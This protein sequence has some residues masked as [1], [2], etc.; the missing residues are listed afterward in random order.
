MT[1]P[2][3]EADRR[4]SIMALCKKSK[5]ALALRYTLWRD[6]PVTFINDCVWTFDPD[7]DDSVR[8]L[9]LYPKQ[10]ELVRWLE[11]RFQAREEGIVEKSRQVG[12]SWVSCAFAVHKWLF[13]DGC[14]TAFGSRKEDLVDK[15]GDPK[16]LFQKLRFIRE[17]LPAWVRPKG[18]DPNQHDKHMT[19]VNPANGSTITGEAGDNIGRGGTFRLYF[20]DEAAFIDR[21]EDVERA[22]ADSCKARIYVSTPNGPANVFYKKAH[23]GIFPKFRLHWKDDPRKT[24][25]WYAEQKRKRDPLDVARELD[26]NYEESAEDTLIPMAWIRAAVE[27]PLESEAPLVFALDVAAH[28]SNKNALARCRTPVVEDVSTWG[29][30][31]THQTAHRAKDAVER[32]G[33]AELRYDVTGVGEGVRGALGALDHE[34]RFHVTP[35]EFGAGP[36]STW[37]DEKPASDKFSNLRA[38]MWWEVRRRF[39]RT[40]ER[41]ERGVPHADEDCISIPDDEELI[42]QLGAPTY[43]YMTQGKIQIEAKEAMR[44]RGVQSPDK[45]DAVVMGL[46]SAFSR[47]DEYDFMAAPPG[48]SMGSMDL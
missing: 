42:L 39:E 20:I 5:D 26:I 9:A 48:L 29:G 22:L 47:L 35:V 1:D 24:D 10:V 30:L 14:A 36:S 41:K 44:K 25:E 4:L 2:T 16:C 45:A 46:S 11:E 6:D 13:H 8:P 32:R 43:K 27:Y 33:G 34:P 40:F 17:R 38:E 7:A 21:S 37:Y 31:D 3:Q 15:R 19:I 28:G 12:V 18:F 23:A